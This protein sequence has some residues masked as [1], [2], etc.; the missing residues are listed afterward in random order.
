RHTRSLRDWS[1]DV[2]SS[3]LAVVARGHAPELVAGQRGAGGAAAGLHGVVGAAAGGGSD[4]GHAVEVEDR[5]RG[6]LES[7]DQPWRAGRPRSEERRVGK[8]GGGRWAPW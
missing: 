8:E 3:D 1:S 2:C 5:G 6:G 7:V 4:L